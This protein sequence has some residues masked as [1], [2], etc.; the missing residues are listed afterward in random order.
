MTLAAKVPNK[1]TP[2]TEMPTL[3]T[4]NDVNSRYHSKRSQA[5]FDAAMQYFP[6]PAEW[7]AVA[8]AT[9]A[10][11]Y[12]HHHCGGKCWYA[13][14]PFVLTLGFGYCPLCY[15]ACTMKSNVNAE[16]AKLPEVQQLL[17]RG[18]ALEWCPK[19]KLS[20]GGMCVYASSAPPTQKVMAR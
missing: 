16:I 2:C 10:V 20:A 13:M 6:D 8:T 18:I 7:E 12:K 1:I 5:A 3:P 11:I 15:V 17:A 14:V 9:N 19:G 4:V